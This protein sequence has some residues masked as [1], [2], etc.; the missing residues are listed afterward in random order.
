MMAREMDSEKIGEVML[1]VTNLTTGYDGVD[2]VKDVSFSVGNN[3]NL[4]II[5]PNG[6]GKTT[7]LRAIANVLPYRG[8]VKVNGKLLSQMRQ[9]DVSLKIAMLS[10]LSGIYF[11][12]TVFETVM[13]G[14]YLHI[15]DKLF[16]LPSKQDK[17][18]VNSCLEAVNMAVYADKPITEL[19]GGQLQ[20]VF[21]ARTLAQAPDI[22]L[23][24]EP[25]NH[26]DLKYQIELIDYL[27]QWAG[28][29][30]RIVIGVMHDINLAMRLSEHV[31]VMKDGK[32]LVKGITQE[33]ISDSLLKEVYGIDVAGY[34][35]QSLKKW[36]TI[37]A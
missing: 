8:D 37:R 14:R 7:M 3:E 11:Q 29:S 19:S 20:R 34:M 6:C 28:D 35:R 13:M 18:I 31:L 30:G 15:K 27:K 10:Q 12:Y 23:L 21:L 25:T 24:D 32:I 4:S 22:I 9:K 36:E 2:I 26:L 17:D 1:E 5:G 16:G 33:I